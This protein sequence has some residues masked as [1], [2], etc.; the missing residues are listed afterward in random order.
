MTE[1]QIRSSRFQF[2]FKVKCGRIK[3]HSSLLF[4]W[5]MRSFPDE[6]QMTFMVRVVTFF[7]LIEKLNTHFLVLLLLGA[8]WIRRPEFRCAVSLW[9]PFASPKTTHVTGPWKSLFCVPWT[10]W[11]GGEKLRCGGKQ[12]CTGQWIRFREFGLLGTS[13]CYIC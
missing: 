2:I 5:A 7:I 6:T 9:D 13:Q 11:V 4:S 8:G 3:D 12:V 1:L 10:L